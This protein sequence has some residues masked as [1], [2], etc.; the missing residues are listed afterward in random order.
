MLF[1][2]KDIFFSMGKDKRRSV[3]TSGAVE[4]NSTL[5]IQGPSGSGKTTLLRTLARLRPCNNGEVFFKN[6]S[7][8]E[9]PGTDWRYRIHYL[10]Q[11][12]VLFDGTVALNM[13]KPFEIS[14]I[15]KEKQF[16]QDEAKAMLSR[17][18]LPE[19]IWNQDASTLSGGEITRI[20]FARA[21]LIDPYVL[22]L[23]EP[24][25]SLD[26]DSAKALY[27]LLDLWL[28]KPD[29]ACILV[30]HTQDYLELNPCFLDLLVKEE[31]V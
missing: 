20:A 29:K 6:K 2:F 31:E 22:L 16:C 3:C 23:D 13:A 19:D 9:F 8:R 11:R 12:P 24:T 10:A 18:L 30:S 27:S 17:L 15:N 4:Q 25:A 21:L 5:V 7:W 26:Y 14:T 28:Q 1:S